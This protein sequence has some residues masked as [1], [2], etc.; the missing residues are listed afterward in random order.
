L[1]PADVLVAGD[2][3]VSNTENGCE[4]DR[5]MFSVGLNPSPTVTFTAPDDLC[6]DAGAQKV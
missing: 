5:T 4:S 3:Y 2:Y 6:I 1:N